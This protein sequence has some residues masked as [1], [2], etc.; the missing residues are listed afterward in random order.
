MKPSGIIS[1]YNVPDDAGDPDVKVYVNNEL[2]EIG[3]GGGESDFSLVTMTVAGEA[4]DVATNFPTVVNAGG[5]D[6][7][8]GGGVEISGGLTYPV[9]LYKGVAFV[10]FT[11]EVTF[12]VSGDAEIT[13]QMIKVTG[14][15]TLTISGI[16]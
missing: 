8:V 10:F 13:G 15:F 14:D 4:N 16:S 2:V 9:I 12:T 7:A 11:D 6:A 3:G 1:F 5:T